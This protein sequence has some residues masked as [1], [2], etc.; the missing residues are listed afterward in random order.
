MM[1]H[2]SDTTEDEVPENQIETVVVSADD[3]VSAIQ[4]NAR[5]R[6]EQRS[7]VLRLSPPFDAA[8]QASIHV[9][10]DHTYYPPEMDP[11][12]IHLNP[13]QFHDAEFGY[14]EQ[15]EVHEAAKEVDGVDDISDVS[16]ETLAECW[17]TQREV[18]E[19][20]VRHSL[21]DEIDLNEYDH[22]NSHVVAVE[23]EN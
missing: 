6:D 21:K 22:G 9:S 4:R 11:K 10:E 18:W 8:V 1:T 15:W 12:P 14:P 5:D 20:E 3:I 2:E 19:S 23:Y 17:D 7:H 16:D 13:D